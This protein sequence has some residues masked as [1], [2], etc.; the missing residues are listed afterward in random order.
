MSMEFD[1]L[2]KKDLTVTSLFD[3]YGELLPPETKEILHLKYEEDFSYSEIAEHLSISRQAVHLRLQRAV[4]KLW[5]CETALHGIQRWQERQAK[6]MAAE[7]AL[8]A[9]DYEETRR[10]LRELEATDA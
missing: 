7:R 8:Q 9:A 10:I 1:A 4:Q 6:Y 2:L 3:F 5:E